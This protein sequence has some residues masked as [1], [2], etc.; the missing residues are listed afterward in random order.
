ME[1]EKTQKEYTN[2]EK[3]IHALEEE[4][5]QKRPW[6]DNSL[7]LVKTTEMLTLY[8]LRERLYGLKDI[9]HLLRTQSPDKKYNLTLNEC[10]EYGLVGVSGE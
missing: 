5:K 4:K 8:K 6:Y 9:N 10:R 7:Y 3:Y 2:Q 1:I